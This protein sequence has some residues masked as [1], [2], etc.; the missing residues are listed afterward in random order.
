VEVIHYVHDA[1]LRIRDPAYRA[2]QDRMMGEIIAALES[3]RLPGPTGTPF[4]VHPRW[5][6]AAAL[7]V[8]AILHWAINV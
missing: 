2:M 8:V 5:L 1:D 4:S 6:G 7:I 3:G